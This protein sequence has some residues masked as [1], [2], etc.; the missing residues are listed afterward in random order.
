[1]LELEVAKKAAMAGGQI[2]ANYFESGLEVGQKVGSDGSQIQTHNL[3]SAAD[4]ESENAIAKIIQESFPDHA[5]LGEENLEAD[6]SSE[7]LWVIDPLDGTNN[8]VHQ[9]PHFAVSI[10]YYKNGVGQCGVVYNPVRGD[11]Y[12]VVCGQGAYHNDGPVSVSDATGLD[13]VLVG[14]GF[15]YDRGKMMRSTLNAIGDV[16]EKRIHG[17][18]RM[19]TASLDLCMVGTGRYGAFFEYELAPWD[20]AAGQLFVQEAG[21]RV[22]DCLGQPL[23]LGRTSILVTNSKLHEETLAI[24]SRHL[25]KD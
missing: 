12:T 21:G 6:V 1:M 13:Q 17:I 11:W 5:L 18:R 7:H 2:I 14:V 10:G 3:V 15:Y 24:V 19:G 25:P 23:K 4:L 22:T 16:F 8:F 9:V 20:F